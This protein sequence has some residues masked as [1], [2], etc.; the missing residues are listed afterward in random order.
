MGLCMD[1]D[2]E[3]WVYE[4]GYGFIYRDMGSWVYAWR[5]VYIWG[6]GFMHGDIGF[7]ARGLSEVIIV[8]V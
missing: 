5:W 1:W 3:L 6:Y 8:Y 2:M 4:W 7:Y